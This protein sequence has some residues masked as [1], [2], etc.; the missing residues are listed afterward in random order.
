MNEKLENQI[1]LALSGRGIGMREATLIA[2]AKINY[3][4][5]LLDDEK[6][7]RTVSQLEDMAMVESF[8]DISG[9]PLWALTETGKARLREQGL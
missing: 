3:G 7:M 9:R 8:P 1:L 2:A 4:D 6:I 5:R